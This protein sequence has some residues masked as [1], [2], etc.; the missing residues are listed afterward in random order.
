MGYK[1][2]TG[3]FA[4]VQQLLAKKE[5]QKAAYVLSKTVLNLRKPG[6]EKSLFQKLTGFDVHASIAYL[7]R[8]REFYA[9]FAY[10]N[11]SDFK[12][13]IHVSSSSSLDG[14]RIHLAMNLSVY[15]FFIDIKEMLPGVLEKYPVLFYTA[16]FDDVF[17]AVNLENQLRKLSW[18]HSETYKKACRVPWRHNDDYS[19]KLRG[20]EKKVPGLLSATVLFGGHYIYQDQSQAVSELY[21][22]FLKF[23]PASDV[24]AESADNGECYMMQTAN[25]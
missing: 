11:S 18:K 8:P 21:S 25:T 6:E 15:D 1:N 12:K 5:F 7:K 9:Y 2:F 16:Q 3:T 24:N 23:P 4:I 20:Y 17:P 10:A 13:R 14:K 22:R 19:G